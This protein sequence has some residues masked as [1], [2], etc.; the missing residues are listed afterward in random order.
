MIF[1]WFKRRRRRRILATPFPADWLAYL[2]RNVPQYRLLTPHEQ[3]KLRQRVQVFVHEKKW[4]GC[5]GLV[6]NDEIKV[7]IAAQACLLVLGIDYEYHYDQIRSL[8][9]YPD[10]YLHPPD[11]H[12]GVFR[13]GAPVYGETWHRGPI[14]LSWKNT[15]GLADEEGGNLVFHEF[16]HHLDDL[17]GGMD[18]MPPL[19]RGQQRRWDRVIDKEY[20]RLRR[21]S[22]QGRATLLNE[23]GASNR[24]EFFAVATECFFERPVAMR[25]QHPELYAIL[26]DFFRQDPACWPW[27]LANTD[28]AASARSHESNGPARPA[29]KAGKWIG[30]RRGA[31]DAFFSEGVWLM[32]EHRHEEAVATFDKAIELAPDDAE[33]LAHRALARVKSG[34]PIRAMEDASAAIRLDETDSMAW[35]VR[36]AAY[37]ASSQYDEA[38]ADC[39]RAIRLDGHNGEAYRLRGLAF[40]GLGKLRKALGDYGKAL[41]FNANLADTLRARAE[42]HER[43]GRLDKAQADR[44]KAARFDTS[45]EQGS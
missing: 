10:T 31:A 32:N 26:R 33:A 21:A 39:Q 16:A 34:E 11:I 12:D 44:D 1:S 20:H 17:D 8:L 27:E 43:L 4:I 5:G 37:L 23:Y 36:A 41:H 14:V 7:T 2:K 28:G 30:V 24:A 3:A 40:A 25:E 35:R 18:G 22:L 6:I 45:A 15:L 42:A 19:E 29:R 13:N 9:V 38:L